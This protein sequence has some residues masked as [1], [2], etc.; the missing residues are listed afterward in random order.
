MKFVKYSSGCDTSYSQVTSDTCSFIFGAV[1]T[2]SE[3]VVLDELVMKNSKD[4]L[5]APS[6]IALKYI[7]FL[8]KNRKEWGFA[9]NN[10]IDC[11]DQATISELQ[12]YKNNHGSIYEFNN[13]YKKVEIIDRI[14]MQIGW[15]DTGHYY[16]LE[17]CKNHIDELNK[18]SWD[19]KK[20]DRPE[21]AH[22]H[23]INASQYAWIP[24]RTGIGLQPYNN[25]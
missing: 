24:Y 6:D 7:A 12:K 11:S 8:E 14:N 1:S 13:S 2:K 19:E 4:E 3:F 5:F 10:F 18:Y 20:T 16:V 25:K 9:K 15:L 22:D 17:H 23:T 21:D